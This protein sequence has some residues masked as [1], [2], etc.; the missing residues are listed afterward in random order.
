[1]LGVPVVRCTVAETTAL[2]AAYLAGL[3]AGIWNSPGEVRAHW[4]QAARFEPRMPTSQAQSLRADWGAAV[5]R[6]KNWQ[7]PS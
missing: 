7:Q 3:G 5:D 2:G 6:A 1:V 4:Q